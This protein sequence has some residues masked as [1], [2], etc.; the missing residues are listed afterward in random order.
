MKTRRSQSGVALVITLIM[1]AVITLIAVA[2]LALSQRERASISQSIAGTEAELMAN[3]ALERAK[4]HIFAQMSSFLETNVYTNA[5]RDVIPLRLA[6]GPDLTVSVA[7]RSNL[8]G[9]PY[10]Y[11][12]PPNMQ[13]QP[14]YEVLTNLFFDPPPPVFTTNRTGSYE[15]V[16]YLDLNRNGRFEDS[17]IVTN[18]DSS[19]RP[20]ADQTHYAVGDPQWIGMLAR[21]NEPHSASNRFIGRYAF[22]I[23][24]AGRTLDINFI[25][26]RATNANRFNRNQGHGS[27]ELNLAAF[28]S[29]LNSNVWTGYDYGRRAGFGFRDADEILTFRYNGQ[30]VGL[31][32]GVWDLFDRRAD[33]IWFT[34]GIDQYA[35][36]S[37]GPGG[38]D[39]DPVNRGWSGSPN[40]QHFLNI[41][42]FFNPKTP[43]MPN[44][45][46]NLLR[47]GRGSGVTWQSNSYNSETF[48]RMLAQLG[49]DTATEKR[50][51]RRDAA[52]RFVDEARI[53][54]NYDNL[55]PAT[56]DQFTNWT[57]ETF[58]HTAADRLLRDH[59][60]VDR[61]GRFLSVTNL[62]VYPTNENYYTPAVHRILQMTLNIFDTK[63]HYGPARPPYYPTVLQPYFR[64]ENVTNVF[65]S[66]YREL[67]DHTEVRQLARWRDLSETN[68]FATN[69][70]V[71]VYGVPL[72]V[73]A[74]KG[75]PNFNEMVFQTTAQVVRKLRVDKS[76]GRPVR[77]NQLFIIGVSNYLALEAWNSYTSTYPRQLEL[78]VGLTNRTA[79]TNEDPYRVTDDFGIITNISI[80]QWKGGQFQVPVWTNYIVL[81]DSAYKDRRMRPPTTNEVNWELGRF[82]APQ[83]V[84][85]ANTKMRFFLFDGNRLVDAVGLAPS[86]TAMNVTKELHDLDRSPNPLGPFT[87]ASAVPQV[88]KTNR[89]GGA[90]FNQT[91]IPTEGVIK[92]LEISQS[93]WGAWADFGVWD[94]SRTAAIGFRDFLTSTNVTSTNQMTAPFTPQHKIYQQVVWQ[95]NDPL[96]HHIVEDLSFKKPTPQPSKILGFSSALGVNISL[97]NKAYRPWGGNTNSDLSD[98][99]RNVAAYDYR[100]KDPLVRG[101]DNW[102]FTTNFPG[103]G[104]LGRVHRGTPWQTLYLKPEAPDP[105]TWGGNHQG[106]ALS[107]PTNDWR[108]ADVFTVAQY[109]TASRG[110][111][112][113]NQTNLAAWSAL[114]SG[115]EVP[116]LTNINGKVVVTNTIIQPVVNEINLDE[117]VNG[118]GGI[119]YR[120]QGMTGEVFSSLSEFLSI[121]NLVGTNSPY[122][123]PPYVTPAA[124]AEAADVLTDADYEAIP[125]QILS[126][127]KPGE[128]RFVVYAF[129][130]S[131]KPAP[132]SI[133]AGGPFR[134]LCRNYEVTGELAA[135]AVMRVDSYPQKNA[136]PRLQAVIESYNILPPD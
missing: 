26:N 2:F 15:H 90:A 42:D 96:V 13:P 102:D 120:R 122:L 52:G 28:L 43:A 82:P 50:Q 101:S 99:G 32:R 33:S 38:A 30:G 34:D 133:I 41:H 74:K 4:G 20:I 97:V 67:A 63:P 132:Q 125:R 9:Q 81:P 35:D 92:Q 118:I 100:V 47:S 56:A 112:S 107:N 8:N 57:A 105:K 70:S 31:L 110:L 24:P 21:P 80:G 44:F 89:Y 117:L 17:G 104:W 62:Q 124:F 54:L 76:N 72:L 135:K 79:L 53:N 111:M 131:L 78:Y 69:Q 29:N 94:S 95:V 60:V 119:N 27:W 48:Y 91:N 6:L 73:G 12:N 66:G 114:L 7:A 25:H 130:Q 23:A 116:T 93:T 71:F 109:P 88:W 115:V 39:R 106:G 113:V 83:W 49:T 68:N 45:Q 37:G 61:N 19:G 98:P 75:F 86:V 134:G 51:V 136:P 123:R 36:G 11:T 3:A 18:L 103:I 84:L 5:L 14:D 65:I 22:L 64:T 55:A 85:E 121:P 77:T 16:H 10:F 87:T 1:L 128:P 58:F 59:G 127:L 40:P 108:L 129:G 126:L 46:F